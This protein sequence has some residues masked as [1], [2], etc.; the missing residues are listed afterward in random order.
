MP[1]SKLHDNNSI[2]TIKQRGEKEKGTKKKT[3]NHHQRFDFLKNI[4]FDVP[5]QRKMRISAHRDFFIIVPFF[6]IIEI[7]IIIMRREGKEF[8]FCVL[9]FPNIKDS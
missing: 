3:G 4:I 9:S 1:A 6:V 5:Y 8:F 7:I 2:I